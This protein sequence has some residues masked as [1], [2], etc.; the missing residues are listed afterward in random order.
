MLAQLAFSLLPYYMTREGI[1]PDLAPPLEE[2]LARVAEIGFAGVPAEVPASLDEAGYAGL[3]AQHGLRCAPGYFQADFADVDGRP[4]MVEAA[5]AAARS[6][7]RLG[8]DRI[9]IA[10]QFPNAARYAAPGQGACADPQWLASVIDGLAPACAA[11]VAEG[12]TPCLHP[13]VGSAIEV[14]SEIEAVLA[15]IPSSQLLAGPDIG[16]LGWAGLDPVQFVQR[17]RD[18]IGAVHF[19]DMRKAVAVD[20]AAQGR[21]YR[22]TAW[23]GLWTAPGRGDVGCQQ[24]LDALDGFSG[25]IVAEIDI[26]DTPTVEE[27]ARQAYAWFTQGAD[28]ATNE[29]VLA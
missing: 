9:F 25:W 4:A 24:V 12:V 16:H 13:H 3:L 23:G 2:L 1:R 26:P 5:A 28:S 8:L 14:E 29:G 19:K 20:G 22:E 27:V 18:R 6:H 15:A 11:M 7:A 10:A 21:N 17:H